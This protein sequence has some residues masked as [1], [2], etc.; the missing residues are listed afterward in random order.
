MAGRL[1]QDLA[2]VGGPW[3]L[4]VPTVSPDG[5]RLALTSAGD[6]WI[7]ELRRN[8]MMRLTFGG[9]YGNPLWSADGRYIA[10]RSAGGMFW[11]RGDG[12]GNPQQLT[13]SKNLQVPWSFSA[14]GRRL[15]FVE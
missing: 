8:T 4:S 9:G 15:A 7:Y 10:F 2:A 14:D 6:I 12:K 13:E 5:N 11:T 3:K 1:G